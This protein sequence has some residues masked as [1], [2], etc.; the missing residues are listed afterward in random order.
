MDN[1]AEEFEDDLHE[2]AADDDTEGVLGEEDNLEEPEELPSEEEEYPE[3]EEEPES[4]DETETS[5]PDPQAELALARS[6][7][8]KPASEWK[9][10]LPEGFVDDPAEYNRRYEERMPALVSENRQARERIAALESAMRMMADRTNAQAKA[11]YEAQKR[12]IREKH[13]EAVRNG[14]ERRA[15]FYLD[16]LEK[17]QLPDPLDIPAAEEPQEP[18]T[19]QETPQT[20]KQRAFASWIDRNSWYNTPEGRAKGDRIGEILVSRGIITPDDDPRGFLDEISDIYLG[21]KPMPGQEKQV[22]KQPPAPEGKRTAPRRPTSQNKPSWAR[23]P[24]EAREIAEEYW[25]GK[26]TAYPNTPEGRQKYAE[27]Y[28]RTVDTQGDS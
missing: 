1:L 14:D 21:I 22:R 8:W 25:I 10:R 20:D 19:P 23:L 3:A 5:E 17:L 24:R 9:G 6:R 13:R 11:E 7:G 27:Q 15:E 18:E 12:Q 4:G 16:Q 2:E 26:S 28:F